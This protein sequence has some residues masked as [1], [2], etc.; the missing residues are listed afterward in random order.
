MFFLFF[1]T[2]LLTIMSPVTV[3]PG[4]IE[5]LPFIQSHD[6][7]H[8]TAV[9]PGSITQ[10]YLCVSCIFYILFLCMCSKRTK[11]PTFIIHCTSEKFKHLI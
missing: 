2:D 6:P 10:P 8:H 3:D 4:H 7:D 5:V 1:L 9:D 11:T